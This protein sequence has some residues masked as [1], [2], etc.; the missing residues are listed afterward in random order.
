MSSIRVPKKQQHVRSGRLYPIPIIH[1]DFV[2]EMVLKD[3]MP[4]NLSIEV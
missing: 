2:L 4:G 3:G 1:A